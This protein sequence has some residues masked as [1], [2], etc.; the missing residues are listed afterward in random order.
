MLKQRRIKDLI[1]AGWRILEAS[2]DDHKCA[3]WKTQAIDCLTQLLGPDHIYVS[4]LKETFG[5]AGSLS[6]LSATGILDAAREQ[7]SGMALN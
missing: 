7:L 4:Y 3:Q 1:E 6:V 5:R 2:S